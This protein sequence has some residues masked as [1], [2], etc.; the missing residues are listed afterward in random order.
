MSIDKILKNFK[1]VDKHDKV[2][3]FIVI[4]EN[5]KIIDTVEN[6]I[7]IKGRQAIMKSFFGKTTNA[8][9]AFMF[10]DSGSGITND[11]DQENCS[12]ENPRFCAVSAVSS[13]DIIT[14]KPATDIT[15]EDS[16]GKIVLYDNYCYYHIQGNFSFRDDEATQEF[17]VNSI[18]L[19]FNGA[20]E[21]YDN[22]FSRAVINKKTFMAGNTY[23]I[24]YYFYF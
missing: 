20:D 1:N 16:V 5:N 10:V 8:V 3:G 24:D 22:I 19:S 7:T 11:A 12:L 9:P 13:S 15:E 21:E 14:Q 6:M 23:T 17:N 4:K 2:R 18:G